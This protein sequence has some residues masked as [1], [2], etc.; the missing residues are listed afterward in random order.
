MTPIEWHP[1]DPCPNCGGPMPLVPPAPAWRIEAAKDPQNG[2]PVPQRFDT[3]PAK[4]I[5]EL[6]DLYR[7]NPCDSKMR[8]KPTAP[9]GAG[10]GA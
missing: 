9:T 10:T 8:V 1:G 6:G 5:E 3:A 2:V 7:C 4:V